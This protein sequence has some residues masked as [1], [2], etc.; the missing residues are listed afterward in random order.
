MLV[1]KDILIY[2]KMQVGM[3]LAFMNSFLT[4]PVVEAIG[5]I[6]LK[7]YKRRLYDV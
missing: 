2:N 7:E 1:I 4:N 3:L 5:E 6:K